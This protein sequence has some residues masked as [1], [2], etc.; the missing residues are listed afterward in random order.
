VEVAA[1]AYVE[2]DD[3]FNYNTLATAVDMAAAQ[4]RVMATW[5][6]LRAALKE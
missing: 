6:A 2:A 4:A 5:A 3:I 1:R